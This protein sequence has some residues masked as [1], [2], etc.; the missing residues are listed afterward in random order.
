MECDRG[1]YKITWL[2]GIGT[3]KS[4][5]K[6]FLWIVL[7]FPNSWDRLVHFQLNSWSFIK[8]TYTLHMQVTRLASFLMSHKTFKLNT[9]ACCQFRL[10]WPYCASASLCFPAPYH[11]PK[12]L[13][14]LYNQ[15][16]LSSHNKKYSYSLENL[17]VRSYA[18]QQ[19]K[20]TPEDW[21]V[22]H[23]KTRTLN[24]SGS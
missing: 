12:L 18:F 24:T 21:S 3:E 15:V 20:K 9:A 5:R 13:Y 22:T 1:T 11:I 17:S 8:L 7:G 23:K 14:S 16:L 4:A 2:A 10:S 6:F 19:P